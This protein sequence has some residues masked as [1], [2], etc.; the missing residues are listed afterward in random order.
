MRIINGE[1]PISF[2]I[3]HKLAKAFDTTPEYWLNL[4]TKYDVWKYRD[5][6]KEITKSIPKL[7]ETPDK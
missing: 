2:T 1:V 7:V 4:Q 6:Y 5:R 3:A